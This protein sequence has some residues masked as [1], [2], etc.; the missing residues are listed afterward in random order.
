MIGWSPVPTRYQL[1]SPNG[2]I[3][4]RCGADLLLNGLRYDVN[5]KARCPVCSNTIKFAVRVHRVVDLEPPEAVLYVVENPG[6]DAGIE[7]GSTHLFDNEACLRLWL[8]TYTGRKGFTYTL[9][10]FTDYWLAKQPSPIL[11]K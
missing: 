10:G 2:D 4:V 7:C 11:A 8:G 1:T 6:P 5:A 9:H 3:Y